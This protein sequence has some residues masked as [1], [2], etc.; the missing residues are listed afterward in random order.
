MSFL[1]LRE[2][3]FGKLYTLYLLLFHING[4]YQPSELEILLE[5]GFRGASAIPRFVEFW[6]AFGPGS[7]ANAS[8]HLC[9]RGREDCNQA[10][11]PGRQLL[12][13]DSARI[14]RVVDLEE[15][16]IK[17]EEVNMEKVAGGGALPQGLTA[18]EERVAEV[19]S[20]LKMK[21]RASLHDR[22]VSSSRQ[23]GRATEK[24]RKMRTRHSR[25]G[26]DSGSSSFENEG[27][28]ELLGACSASFMGLRELVSHRPGALYQLDFSQVARHMRSGG[29]GATRPRRLSK[30]P[31][32]AVLREPADSQVSK[33]VRP[34]RTGTPN[35]LR[36]YG[37]ARRRSAS[38]GGGSHDA[39]SN[40]S[41]I[42]PARLQLGSSW[43][44]GDHRRCGRSDE[45][46]RETHG[47][48]A[49]AETASARGG[50][51][52]GLERGRRLGTRPGC[53]ERLSRSPLATPASAKAECRQVARRR[54]PCLREHRPS[55]AQKTSKRAGVGGHPHSERRHSCA[56]GTSV[57]MARDGSTS[58]GRTPR[59]SA[60]RS[61]RASRWPWA[62]R[63]QWQVALEEATEQVVAESR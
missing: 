59:Q 12:H 46:G 48:Q 55:E 3:H 8:L 37:S 52:E 15:S 7:A 61:L 23:H 38:R 62:G 45:L 14:R 30:G 34:H 2:V 24:L 28:K 35:E 47:G 33:D 57:G 13:V 43:P 42:D 56:G 20:R 53:E 31:Q 54:R 16:W 32:G 36:G 60:L 44:A 11:L 29:A 25:S 27:E 6:I 9:S 26:S 49:V 39:A 18:Q 50:V 51:Q 41:G 63:R 17:L 4:I 5:V 1:D 58:P 21:K 10:V 22:L 40:G 19:R